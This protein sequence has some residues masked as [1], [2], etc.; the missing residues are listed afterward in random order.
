[1]PGTASRWGA[2]WGPTAFTGEVARAFRPYYETFYDVEGGEMLWLEG[3][4]SHGTY[5]H[6]NLSRVYVTTHCIEQGR[7]VHTRSVEPELR[8][9][10]LCA[11]HFV[12]VETQTCLQRGGRLSREAPP[13]YVTF[14]VC[15]FRDY[16]VI[17]AMNYVAPSVLSQVREMV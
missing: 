1:M 14:G 9:E 8:D 2:G 15:D 7:D 16:R 10:P 11:W 4:Y 5:T 6:V 17:V 13:M 12:L 3:E